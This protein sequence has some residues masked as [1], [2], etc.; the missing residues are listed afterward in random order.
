MALTNAGFF[1]DDMEKVKAAN[2]KSGLVY[3]INEH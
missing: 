2:L 1:Y 3:I